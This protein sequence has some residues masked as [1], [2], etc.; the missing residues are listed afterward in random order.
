[1]AGPASAVEVD[2]LEC[3][4]ASCPHRADILHGEKQIATNLIT[5]FHLLSAISNPL[6]QFFFLN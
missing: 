1:M 3:R 5:G 2:V 6:P 4:R